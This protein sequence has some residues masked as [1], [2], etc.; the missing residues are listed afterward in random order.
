MHITLAPM[1][2]VV[3]HLMRDMLTQVGGFD[4]CVTEFVRVV[5]TKLPKKVFYRLCPE[6]H[7]GGLT[8]A[9]VPV[10]VQLLGQHPEWMAENAL[11]AIELGSHGIDIN[12]G[13]P[14]K[15]VNKS[16]GGAVLLQYPDMLYKIVKA[17][18]DAVPIEHAVTAKIRLG[19]ND[20]SLALENADAIY[21]AG[22]SSLAIHARTKRDG[23]R[24]PAYWPWIAK[25]K[26]TVDMPLVAN[27]EI[28]SAADAT[29]CQEQS[30]C[31]NL[32]LGR[33]ALALPNLAKSIKINEA[34]M[35]WE[36]LKLLLIHYSG[37]EI[38]GDKGRYYPNRIKQWLSYLKIQYPEAESLFIQIRKLNNAKDIVDV[39]QK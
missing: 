6:L 24:P 35:S 5:Q 28:W 23:Y 7:H 26:A 15:T 12:F 27:G 30:Q 33:G 2:G 13:C 21:Q 32:M 20:T 22:A 39:L 34:P 8:P 25:I 11:T 16:Q 1:E 31:T 3:D 38:Y 14:A 10:K 18:R 4:L 37:Y 19:F 17:V 9:G 36:A 29:L